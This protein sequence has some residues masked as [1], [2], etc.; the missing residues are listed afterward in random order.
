MQKQTKR[1]LVTERRELPR[2][3]LQ[4]CLGIQ[5]SNS[6]WVNYSVPGHAWNN[7]SVR[8]AAQGTYRNRAQNTGLGHLQE[9]VRSSKIWTNTRTHNQAGSQG[10]ITRYRT[11]ELIRSYLD[12]MTRPGNLS[13][14]ATRQEHNTTNTGPRTLGTDWKH[15]TRTS[16]EL[17]RETRYW[18]KSRL[19]DNMN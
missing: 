2:L 15:E 1:V 5:I 17:A 16:H 8:Q 14:E 12:M 11:R 13:Q 9:T 7:I 3:T 19:V 4:V 10:C 6:G 18:N